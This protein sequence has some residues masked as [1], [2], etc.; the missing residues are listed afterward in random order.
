MHF[1]V[2]DLVEIKQSRND[3]LGIVVKKSSPVQGLE[4]SKHTEHILSSY[5][6]VYY[7]YAAN[8]SCEGPYQKS[9]LKLQQSYDRPVNN[10]S[11]HT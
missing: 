9:E 5:A 6:P 11:D 3:L 4:K 7:V 8:G 2:G 10:M 1:C